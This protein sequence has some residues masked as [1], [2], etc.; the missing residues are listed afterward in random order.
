M[1]NAAAPSDRPVFVDPSGRRRKLLRI[2]I[3]VAAAAV[4]GYLV[5]LAI[6]LGG[7]PIKPNT[8]L[9]VAPQVDQPKLVQTPAPGITTSDEPGTTTAGSSA[10]SEVKTTTTPPTATTTTTTE[11]NGHRDEAPGA[12]NRPTAPGKTK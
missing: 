11:P 7:G 1:T 2:S 9:P 4:V 12:T 3:G 10:P 8:L 6:A 5:L